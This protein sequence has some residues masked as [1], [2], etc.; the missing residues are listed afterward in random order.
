MHHRRRALA[1]RSQ[2]NEPAFITSRLSKDYNN[3]V[4]W[5]F[6]YGRQYGARAILVYAVSMHTEFVR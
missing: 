3:L 2:A 4:K 1:D 5:G 6:F